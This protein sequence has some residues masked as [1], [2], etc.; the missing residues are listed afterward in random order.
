MCTSYW[1]KN[2][3][4]SVFGQSPQHADLR[5]LLIDVSVEGA[6]SSTCNVAVTKLEKSL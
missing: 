2:E 1:V 5:L 4:G 3:I 6:A